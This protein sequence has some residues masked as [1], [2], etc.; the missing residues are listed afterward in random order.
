MAHVFILA[1]GREAWMKLFLKDLG[2]RRYEY[3]MNNGNSGYVQPNAREI[4]LFDISIPESSISSLMA[5]L[6]PFAENTS[7]QR[8]KAHLFANL[9]RESG[10][11]RSI[12]DIGGIPRKSRFR[13]FLDLGLETLHLKEPEKF[14]EFPRT[15]ALRK[16][17]VNIIPIGW[18]EDR[19]SPSDKDGYPHLPHGSEL[20]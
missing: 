1:E 3:K 5:D 10:N 2:E 8:G 11:L 20:L 13:R 15:Y 16:R 17:W 9:L 7:K 18:H 6:S 19:R 14:E 4:K 12:Y